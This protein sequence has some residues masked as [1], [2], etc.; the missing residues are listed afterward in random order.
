MVLSCL[1]FCRPALMT[2]VDG[3]YKVCIHVGSKLI[4]KILLNISPDWL[5]R[6]IGKISTCHQEVVL[7]GTIHIR[8]TDSILK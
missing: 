2:I 7:C 5:N 3:K 6:V 8:S 4:E 1:L